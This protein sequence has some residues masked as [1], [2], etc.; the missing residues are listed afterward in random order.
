MGRLVLTASTG[1]SRVAL[2]NPYG[3]RGVVDVPLDSAGRC[4]LLACARRNVDFKTAIGAANDFWLNPERLIELATSSP[5]T[6]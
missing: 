2:V 3:R 4:Q 6:L 1:T 5:S